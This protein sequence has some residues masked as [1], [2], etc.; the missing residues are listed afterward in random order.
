M[1]ELAES[2]FF[3]PLGW[4]EGNFK[5]GVNIFRDQNKWCLSDNPIHC[6][7]FYEITLKNGKWS[8]RFHIC[9]SYEHTPGNVV[10]VLLQGKLNHTTITLYGTNG[11]G[12]KPSTC[13]LFTVN[14]VYV[15]NTEYENGILMGHFYDG[16]AM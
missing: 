9:Y 15:S 6:L 10:C 5:Q 16:R 4:H 11:L 3:F 14:E 2:G 13:V 8:S 1:S 12:Y 7:F